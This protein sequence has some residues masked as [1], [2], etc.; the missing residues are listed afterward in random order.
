MQP[1]KYKKAKMNLAVLKQNHC[2]FNITK[3]KIANNYETDKL[4]RVI[5]P[6]KL[7]IDASEY[8]CRP[9]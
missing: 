9:V 7:S 4:R 8:S 2:Q 1:F 6:Y 3:K 5:Q